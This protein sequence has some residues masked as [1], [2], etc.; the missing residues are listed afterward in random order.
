LPTHQVDIGIILVFFN[1]YFYWSVSSL[2]LPG[3]ELGPIRRPLFQGQTEPSGRSLAG[4]GVQ[5]PRLP[6]KAQD[7]QTPSHV[8]AQQTPCAQKPVR[9]SALALQRPVSEPIPPQL[10]LTQETPTTHSAGPMQSW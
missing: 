4:T 1:T 5:V 7:E 6:G 9:H 8:D 3:A 2:G 10:L